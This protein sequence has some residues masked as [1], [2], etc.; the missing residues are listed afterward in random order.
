MVVYQLHWYWQ[1]RHATYSQVQ[2]QKGTLK[3]DGTT[4][5]PMEQHLGK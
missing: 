5:R 3:V 2:A 1:V 4:E